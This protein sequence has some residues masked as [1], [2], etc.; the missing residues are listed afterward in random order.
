MYVRCV[1]VRQRNF[2]LATS[3]S[4]AHEPHEDGR[5]CGPE[6]VGAT[7]LKCF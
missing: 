2:N 5:K 7:S 4:T 3:Q 6:H 1:F